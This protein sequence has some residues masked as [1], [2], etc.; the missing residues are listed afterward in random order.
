[1]AD[2]VTTAAA[3]VAGVEVTKKISNF[4]DKLALGF[5]KRKL[6]EFTFLIDKGMP[7]YLASNF[8]KCETIKTL[9]NRNN[10]IDLESCFV[11]PKFDCQ[12]NQILASEILKEINSDAGKYIITGVAGSGKSVFL[13]HSFRSVIEKGYSYYPL[14]FELRQLNRIDKKMIS[15]EVELFESI[16]ASNENFSK[17]KFKY[18][19]KSGGFFIFL[20]GYDELAIDI[21]EKITEE[22]IKIAAVYN[23]CPLVVSSRP[24]SDFVSWEGFREAKL[25]PFELP[26]IKEYIGK[27]KYDDARKGD[28][29]ADLDSIYQSH[30]GFLSNPL[31]CAMMLLT[32]EV[33]GEIPEKRHV[34]YSKCFDVLAIEH[35]A[36]KGRYKR[37]LHSGITVD[38]LEEIFMFFCAFSY[39]D[40]IIEF[41]EENLEKY[42]NNALEA[43][44]RTI[45]VGRVVKDFCESISILQ[46]DGLIFE[47][48][49]R[50]F[51]EYFYAKFVVKDREIPLK[52]KVDWLVS[53]FSNDD[54]V[55]MIY[56]MDKKYFEDEYLLPE[57]KKICAYIKDADPNKNPSKILGKFF[58]DIRVRGVRNKEDKLQPRV[59]YFVKN[60]KNYY[61][62]RKAVL[63]WFEELQAKG[64]NE[65][66]HDG[67]VEEEMAHLLET[68]YRGEVKIH[69][70][71][72]TKLIE[73]KTNIFAARAK[74][75]LL[76]YEIY[77][78]ASIS[79]RKNSIGELMRRRFT[80]Y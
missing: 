61:L 76:D 27:I 72:D 52:K 54:A 9:L 65:Q 8:A 33:F 29:L 58:L 14:F 75:I 16:K 69:H 36:S 20:D 78:K 1:M 2:P 6:D 38:Q 63:H 64:E 11:A 21:K 77:L 24:S 47:F 31:L 62:Y 50:S 51:Q 48:A 4:I 7:E 18:G 37:E 57:I 53:E 28:F 59:S 26:Q 44:G 5:A 67:I 80:R 25:L 40:R 49:H 66:L 73:L 3:G 23:K 74:K 46:K 60:G 43:C 13:K 42:V 35:D 10:P 45:E 55:D 12:E 56:D 32:Y 79:R 22:I 41:D 30:K 34:F 71:N 17:N 39:A 15:L 70:L 68:E 19:L